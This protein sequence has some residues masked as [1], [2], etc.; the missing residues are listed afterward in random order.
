[1]KT[2]EKLKELAAWYRELADRAGNPSIWH[3]RLRTA[4]DLDN[5]DERI[6]H[7]SR[8]PTA[9]APDLSRHGS[10]GSQKIKTHG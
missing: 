4:D 2:A 10:S 3:S 8:K 7:R 6:E 9:R 1:M 5:E